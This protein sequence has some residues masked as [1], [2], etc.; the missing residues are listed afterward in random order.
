[1]ATEAVAEMIAARGLSTG[2]DREKLAE[3]AAFARSLREPQ[4]A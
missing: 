4:D 3:A 2:L 1:M